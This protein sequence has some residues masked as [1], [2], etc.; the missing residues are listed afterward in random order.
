MTPFTNHDSSR[1]SLAIQ[2]LLGLMA[3]SFVSRALSI[4]VADFQAAETT[5]ILGR[6]LLPGTIIKPRSSTKG[7][8]A[9][10]LIGK[11]AP[12]SAGTAT[13]PRGKTDRDGAAT[14]SPICRSGAAPPLRFAGR[15]AERFGY[16]T[17]HRRHGQ[18][19]ELLIE[20]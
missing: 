4:A 20:N 10:E 15:F 14:F 12:V 1:E 17:K 19:R 13:A 6:Q 5:H 3:T 7:S 9:I 16:A 11:T 2:S 18:T 8:L